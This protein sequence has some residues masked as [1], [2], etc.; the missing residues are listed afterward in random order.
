VSEGTIV[1]ACAETAQ[2]VEPICAAVKAELSETTDTE[3]FDMVKL[4]K[5]SIWLFSFRRRC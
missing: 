1:E 5:K 3:H 4:K 2:Q